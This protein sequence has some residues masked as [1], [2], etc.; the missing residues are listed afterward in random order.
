LDDLN[1]RG[2]DHP[3]GKK[4]TFAERHLVIETPHAPWPGSVLDRFGLYAA[5]SHLLA[6]M[7]YL[8]GFLHRILRF[9][10]RRWKSLCGCGSGP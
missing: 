9:L 5:S 8:F 10:Q 7:D 3:G 6:E 2:T 1:C 4:G